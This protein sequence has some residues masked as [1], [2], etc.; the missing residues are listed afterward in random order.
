MATVNANTW[1]PKQLSDTVAKVKAKL[2]V[3]ALANMVA[4]V[5]G[6]DTNRQ[7]G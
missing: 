3:E 7:T 5:L 4:Q 2:L 6:L 1:G